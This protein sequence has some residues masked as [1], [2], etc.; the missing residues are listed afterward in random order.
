MHKSQCA[1]SY[2]VALGAVIVTGTLSLVEN[3]HSACTR[4]CLHVTPAE[5]RQEICGRSGACGVGY[6]MGKVG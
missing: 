1:A 3:I 5:Q 4:R 2:A 6:I